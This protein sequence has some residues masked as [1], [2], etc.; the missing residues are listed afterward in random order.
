VF[1]VGVGVGPTRRFPLLIVVIPLLILILILI[2]IVI[3]IF[4]FAFPPVGA[5]TLL[6]HH[7]LRVTS[8][9]CRKSWT[10]SFELHVAGATSTKGRIHLEQRRRFRQSLAAR[11][12]RMRTSAAVAR[13]RN[14]FHMEVASSGEPGVEPLWMDDREPVQENPAQ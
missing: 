12:Q 3:L 8:R 5:P 13:T 1:S 4:L 2:V 7:P 9:L 10:D 11:I 6:A 14:H